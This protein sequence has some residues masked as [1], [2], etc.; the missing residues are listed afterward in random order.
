MTATPLIDGSSP[1]YI[2]TTST[3]V[4]TTAAFSPPA[5]VWLY[6]LVTAC[7]TL[8]F[9]TPSMSDTVGNDGGGG[10]TL[11]GSITEFGNNSYIFVKYQ[12]VSHSGMTVT[13]T[14]TA[15]AAFIWEAKVC[16]ITNA[17]S[18]QSAASIVSFHSASSSNWYVT[19]TPA[20]SQ[21]LFL[22]C[23]AQTLGSATTVNAYDANTTIGNQAEVVDGSF[24]Q[25]VEW[26]YNKTGP[27]SG[28]ATTVGFTQ[29]SGPPTGSVIG[30]EIIG[31]S[32]SPVTV[33]LTTA[34]VNVAALAP[35]VNIGGLVVPLLTAQVNVAAL[36]PTISAARITS[37][38]SGNPGNIKITYISPNTQALTYSISPVA[39]FDPYGNQ[40]P[41]GYQGMVSAIQPGTIP[42][43][44][45]T[46]HSL[47][48]TGASP[49]GNGVNGFWYRYR[50]DNEVELLWDITLTG[51]ASNICTL[52]T[53][54]TPSTQQNIQSSWYGTGPSVYSN[55]FNPHLLVFAGTGVI[56]VENTN[57]IALS[58]CGRAKI[59]LDVP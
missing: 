8:S 16:V 12:T 29:S 15:S 20:G 10:W 17:A 19:I 3:N 44:T 11:A 55:T 6:A 33:N 35:V 46:W 4:K 49:S 42:A 21:S 23:G 27:N 5:G 58:M 13:I 47:A 40:V 41:A 34:K 7:G 39:S 24:H 32:S 1:A 52:P 51:G 14:T 45:E 2:S 56:Q 50:S 48:L 38:G 36:A 26:G 54:Y 18:D 22:V 25:V 31:S 43:L 9:G 53:G 57:S 37:G 59:T 30:I 28:V